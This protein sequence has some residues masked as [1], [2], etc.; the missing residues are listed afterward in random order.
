MPNKVEM[1]K[2]RDSCESTK[3]EKEN[4]YVHKNKL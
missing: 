1:R 3:I 4:E 2:G